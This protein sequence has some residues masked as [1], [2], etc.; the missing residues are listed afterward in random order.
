MET[1]LR[2]LIRLYRQEV[3]LV[4]IFTRGKEERIFTYENGEQVF[5]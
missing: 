5:W 4:W 3:G 1:Y 2:F